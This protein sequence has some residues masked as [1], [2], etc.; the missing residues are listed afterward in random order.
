M[1]VFWVATP[2]MATLY[3]KLPGGKCPFT[4]GE[5]DNDTLEALP[6]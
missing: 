2:V 4:D 5:L 6:D 3:Y 1:P